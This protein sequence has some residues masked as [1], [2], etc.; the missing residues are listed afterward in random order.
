MKILF[1]TDIHGDGKLVDKLVELGMKEDVKAVMIG[2]DLSPG[3]DVFVQRMFIEFYLLPKLDKLTN[4]GKQVFIQM[5]NDDFGINMDV[6]ESAE[7]RGEVSLIHRK[8]H[9]MDSL[10]VAGYSCVNPS[11]FIFKEWE[12]KEKDIAKDLEELR[13]SVDP[14]KTIFVFHAPPYNTKLDVLHTGDHVG[15]TSIREFIEKT[16]PL[17]TLHGHIHE[18]SRMSG[19]FQDRIGKTLCINPGNDSIAVIDLE[20]MK[21]EIIQ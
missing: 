3:F 13:K 12:R 11:P 20:K 15:S 18:S 9:S 14:K 2:G 5:G 8:A 17:L 16:Q 19:S 10:F 21:A 1:A 6:L 4:A 7:K